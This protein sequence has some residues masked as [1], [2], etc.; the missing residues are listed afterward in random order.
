MQDDR[1]DEEEVEAA[2]SPLTDL[3]ETDDDG[4]PE[5]STD[6]MHSL[7][8]PPLPVPININNLPFMQTFVTNL[9]IY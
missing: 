7:L 4:S 3:T 5:I 6:A 2:L 1:E 8:P 9:F